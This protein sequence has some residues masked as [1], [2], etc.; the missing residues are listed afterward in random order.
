M[1]TWCEEGVH[2]QYT[3]GTNLHADVTASSRALHH[4]NI[5]GDGRYGEFHP[6][7]I[8]LAIREAGCS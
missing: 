1:F 4:V 5:A 2:Q 3:V 8:P 6:G 7:K